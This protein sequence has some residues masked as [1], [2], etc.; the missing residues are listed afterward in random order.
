MIEE[1]GAVGKQGATEERYSTTLKMSS[2]HGNADQAPSLAAQTTAVI[3]E[4]LSNEATPLGEKG[5]VMR[6][7][8]NNLV[9]L[10]RWIDPVDG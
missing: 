6:A 4:H 2:K 10:D 7:L 9:A 8:D 3:M 5:N 1:E